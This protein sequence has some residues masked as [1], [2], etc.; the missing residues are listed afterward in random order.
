MKIDENAKEIYE[1]ATKLEVETN[2]FLFLIVIMITSKVFY[3]IIFKTG[4]QIIKNY[5]IISLL[6][7]YLGTFK[8]HKI[9]S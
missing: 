7:M 1:G 9:K 6:N 2:L 4:T 5:F 8:N 3:F